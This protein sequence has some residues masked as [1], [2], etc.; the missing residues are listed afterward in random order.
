[1]EIQSHDVSSRWV[2]TGDG[3]PKPHGVGD[4]R[5]LHLPYPLYTVARGRRD[6]DNLDDPW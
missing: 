6:W 5:G 1:M 4:M 3:Q 2:L